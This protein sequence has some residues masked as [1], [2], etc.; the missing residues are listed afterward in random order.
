M[1]YRFSIEREDFSAYADKVL[2]HLRGWALSEEGR[3]AGTSLAEPNYE[4][5]R[6]NFNRG[7]AGSD[8]AIEG[9]CLLRKSLHD[10]KMPLNIEVTSG[11][12]RQILDI[13]RQALAGF[14]LK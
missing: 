2:D 6:I 8:P 12:C 7:G 9:W 4:G 10:P 11:S 3:K 1:E 5:V 14:D 13:V